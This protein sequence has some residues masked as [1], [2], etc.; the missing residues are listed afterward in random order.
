MRGA[1]YGIAGF[2]AVKRA[3]MKQRRWM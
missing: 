1:C 3:E 2:I